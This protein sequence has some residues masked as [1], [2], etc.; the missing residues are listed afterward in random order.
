MGWFERARKASA[1]QRVTRADKRAALGYLAEL[2]ALNADRER[3][4]RDGLSGVATIAGIRRN[5][6]T[7]ALGA[8]HELVL[9][10]RLPERDEY[11]ATRRVALE[12][13]TAP[14]ITAGAQVPVRVDPRDLST[15]LVVADR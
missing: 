5:V 3:L 14:H 10:V 1:G 8:W 9:D 12:L 11:R 2:N 7:T 6:A 13:S 4:M 15:V